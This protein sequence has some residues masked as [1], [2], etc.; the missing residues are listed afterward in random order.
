M[1]I[2]A[3]TLEHESSHAAMAILCGLELTAVDALGNGT[4]SAGWIR[5]VVG[6]ED[7]RV[8]TKTLVAAG[9]ETGWPPNGPSTPDLDHL[10]RLLH[11]NRIDASRYY[12]VITE[13]EEVMRSEEYLSL[14]ARFEGALEG[15]GGRLDEQDIRG[16][17]QRWEWDRET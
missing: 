7:W 5:Y 6:D 4:T 17:V 14:K 12:A 10:R 3:D 2:D 11:E 15:A 9:R 16:I 13:A 8:L 1:T